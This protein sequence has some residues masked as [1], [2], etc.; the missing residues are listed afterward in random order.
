MD[1]RFIAIAAFVL[2]CF[3]CAGG[4]P[5]GQTGYEANKAVMASNAAGQSGLVFDPLNIDGSALPDIHDLP[6]PPI[7]PA[8]KYTGIIKNNTRYEV[9]IPSHNSSA[10]ITIPA[11][12]WVEYTAWNS[13][14][15]VTVYHDG[16]PFY[17]L[18][19][20]AHLQNYPF[21]CK[22]YDF[23]AEIVK[24]KPVIRQGPSGPSKLKPRKIKRKVENPPC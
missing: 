15:N 2:F 5:Q 13:F 10:T 3:G 23:I 8:K 22:K 14:F 4:V 1:K 19:I 12:G 24:E 18:N 7:Q 11:Y 20:H 6:T 21:M 16:K 17:C 9:S